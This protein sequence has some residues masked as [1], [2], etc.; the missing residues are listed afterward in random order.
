MKTKILILIIIGIFQVVYS[1][2][3]KVYK[4][5]STILSFTLADV[6]SISISTSPSNK[7][8]NS[9]DWLC[10]ENN[11]IQKSISPSIGIYEDVEDG[12]KVFGSNYSTIQ[13]MPNFQTSLQSKTIYLKWLVNGGGDN[14]NIRVDLVSNT[15]DLN[16]AEEV[17]SFSTSQATSSYTKISDGI[18]YYTRIY[19]SIDQIAATT[20]TGNYDLYGGEIISNLSKKTNSDFIQYTFKT[21]ANNSSYALLSEAWIE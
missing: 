19:I 2:S 12:L 10:F 16:N 6:D 8:A 18:W 21:K 17:L 4:S 9:S 5:D 20:S 13:L 11:T 3:L 1:Q 14:V 7:I 15:S